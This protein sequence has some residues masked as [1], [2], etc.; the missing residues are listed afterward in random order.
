MSPVSFLKHMISISKLTHRRFILGLQGLW[1]GRRYRGMRGLDPAIRL[2]GGLQLD[3]LN[4]IAR[5]QHIA[6]YGRVLDYE[7]EQ[8]HRAAYEKRRFFDYGG[9][10]FLYPISELPYWRLHM[11]RR[12]HQGRWATFR[13]EKAALIAQVLDAVRERGPLGNRDLEGELVEGWNYRGRKDTSLALYY[14]WITGEVMISHREGFDRQYDLRSRVIPPEWEYEIPEPEA[15]E[16]FARKV[17]R[18]AGLL[19]P[20]LFRAGWESAIWRDIN[21]EQAARKLH[22][23]LEAGTSAEVKLEGERLPWVTLTEHLPLLE[24]LESGRVPK[25]WK[26]LGPTTDEEVTVLAPLE[27][28]S[29]RGRA[30]GLFNFDYVWEVYKPLHQRRWGYYT[31]PILYG[32]DLVARF[33]SRLD[34]ANGTLRIL[35]FWLEEDA[36]KDGDFASALG[37][38]LARFSRMA[39]AEKVDGEAITPIRLR[40]EALKAARE[41]LAT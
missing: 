36:P 25:A 23:M 4:I 18:D 11:R 12:A 21:R 22:E 35:G 2:M 34:R 17:L 29:A 6:M 3:P 5:S 40:R 31:L 1:P 32:D 27:P 26:S 28:V 37:R 9:S 30:K 41:T 8:L 33:D 20:T 10:L 38:G 39:G 14:L 24:A 16:Y 13:R 15:E 19:R 7:Q